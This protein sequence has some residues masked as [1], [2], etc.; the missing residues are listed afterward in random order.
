MQ[1]GLVISGERNTSL[2]FDQFPTACHDRLLAA[3]ERIKDRMVTA[4]QAA[5]PNKSG[6]LKGQT[7]GRVYDHGNR[8]AAVAGVRAMTANDAKKAAALEYGS[9]GTPVVMHR[10][11]SGRTVVARRLSRPLV[12]QWTRTPTIAAHRF[13]RGPADSLREGAIDEMRAAVGAAAEDVSR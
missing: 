10:L 1:F 6:A 11:N 12:G 9:R 13:L 4:I 2:R 5:E 8:I 3:M 7:G